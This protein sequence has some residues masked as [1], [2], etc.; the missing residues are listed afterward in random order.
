[1][2]AIEEIQGD[3]RRRLGF[4]DGAEPTAK[5]GTVW[6]GVRQRGS[7][8]R[9]AWSWAGTAIATGP[10]EIPSNFALRIRRRELVHGSAM[11]EYHEDAQS[12]NSTLLVAATDVVGALGGFVR[13]GRLCSVSF[14]GREQLGVVRMMS[15]VPGRFEEAVIT[16]SIDW[17]SA[18]KGFDASEFQPKG[19][20]V[21]QME[22]DKRGTAARGY[23]RA[24]A[25]VAK[26][27]FAQPPG[28]FASGVDLLAKT[29]GT[30]M[31][32]QAGQSSLADRGY[33]PDPT[34]SSAGF[35]AQAVPLPGGY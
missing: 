16:L 18:V 3:P 19:K 12:A 34:S 24:M 9:P 14:M 6:A 4:A 5:G 26:I 33:E 11:V 35:A 1:M 23:E 28:Q 31:L 21:T 30:A 29:E 8:V 32:L 15:P 27:K 10:E 17:L 22:A 20:E 13:R 2:F 7:V 25:L